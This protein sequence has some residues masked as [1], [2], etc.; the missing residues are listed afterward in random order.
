MKLDIMQVG[1]LETN[2]YIV[3]DDEKNALVIDPGANA[4]GIIEFLE[5]NALQC[6][7]ILLTHGHRD[8][9]GALVRL[10]EATGAKV[11]AHSGDV[12]KLPVAPDIL[13][14]G[15]DVI[16]CGALEFSVIETPGHTP[17]GI[18]F[19]CGDSLFSGDTLFCD[20][21]GRTDLDGGSFE[22]LRHSLSTLC[23]LPFADLTVYPGHMQRTTL[24]HER[25]CNPF[26]ER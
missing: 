5:E 15:G 12:A 11:V 23:D 13:V 26:I 21:V 6:E 2:C 22:I 17:G 1:M 25:A 3:S 8:H 14:V 24:A 19:L 20:S 7:Y 9:T 10:K 16:K 18:C 4:R